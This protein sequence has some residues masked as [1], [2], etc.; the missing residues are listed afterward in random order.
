LNPQEAE[1]ARVVVVGGGVSGCA[2]AARLAA[3]GV[4]VT[5]VSSALDVVGLPGYGPEVWAGPGGLAEIMETLDHLP[6]GL[7]WAWLNA[8]GFPESG[9]PVLLM[10]RRAVSI[11]SKRA[12]EAMTGLGF[13]QGLVTE[14]RLRDRGCAAAGTTNATDAVALARAGSSSESGPVVEVETAFGEIFL[15]DAVV[16]CPGLALR[17]QVEVGD[18]VLP[19]GRYGEVPANELLSA[20]EA[21]GVA[22]VETTVEVAPRYASGAPV[23]TAALGNSHL[24]VENGSTLVMRRLVPASVMVPGPSGEDHL[25]PDEFPP[26]PHWTEGLR[27]NIAVLSTSPDHGVVVAPDGAAT[28]EYYVELQDVAGMPKSSPSGAL[29]GTQDLSEGITRLGHRVRALVAV[30]I[31]TR[32]RAPEGLEWLRIAGRSAGAESYLESLKSGVRVADSLLQSLRGF[33]EPE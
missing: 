30:G 1:Q 15:A 33:G 16:L 20:L 6:D 19:G 11:E 7:R 28:A 8:S 3:G 22:F 29:S 5:V 23:V 4:Q 18:E 9:E 13:R 24:G 27:P 25:W 14:V 21:L 2:C 12:L 10:D 17:G 31:D 32:G 26:A